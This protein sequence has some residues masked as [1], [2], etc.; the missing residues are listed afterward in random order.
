MSGTLSKA[1]A[2]YLSSIGGIA[3][4]G[5][6]IIF[7]ACTAFIF[8]TDIASPIAIPE[9]FLPSPSY[10]LFPCPHRM[11]DSTDRTSFR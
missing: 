9:L 1:S 3:S 5:A 6:T 7:S 4:S 11:R 8:L 2:R 10:G